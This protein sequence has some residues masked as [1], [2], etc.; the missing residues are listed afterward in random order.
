MPKVIQYADGHGSRIEDG[1][2]VIFFN[3]RADRARQLTQALIDPEFDGFQRPLLDLHLATISPYDASFNVP[4]AFDKVD[5]TMTLGRSEERR[6]GK[7][8]STQ[9][10]TGQ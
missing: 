10:S 4:V 7:E 8:C 1:D 2:A 6:V 9:W 5:L 3:F